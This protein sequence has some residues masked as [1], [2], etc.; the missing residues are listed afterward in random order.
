MLIAPDDRMIVEEAFITPP[1]DESGGAC[2]L[3]SRSFHHRYK[4]YR[5]RMQFYSRNR[6]DRCDAYR[7]FPGMVML[8]VDVAS[9]R[10]FES[11]LTGQDIVEFHY[12]LSGSIAIEGTWG[13][14]RVHDP[15]CLIWYQPTGCDDA[16]EQIGARGN[17]RETWISLYCDRA[18]LCERTGR[19]ATWLLESL[20]S[21]T[22]FGVG[23]PRFRLQ[24]QRGVTG[25]IVSD[26][27]QTRG[28]SALDWL[29]STAKATEL[30]CTTLKEARL[31]GDLHGSARR[32]SETDQR[33]LQQARDL[34]EAQFATPPRL[35]EL[36]RRVGMNPTKL[37]ALFQN[38]YGESMYD[39]VR[40]RRLE[41]A[42]EL[43][44]R[45]GLQVSQVA[46]AVGYRHHSTFTAAFTQ[47]FG[48]TPK[49]AIATHTVPKM[50]PQA[51]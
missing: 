43:L 34:L 8:I 35:P 12:R 17:G 47:H 29:Y 23:A 46:T 31:A 7:I 4:S 13:H 44:T 11:R 10:P 45:S 16:A 27:M 28:D 37:C 41:R 40:R 50:S 42:H 30:L 5:P 32:P 1:S 6:S 26:L 25:R 20:A 36:A 19:C 9:S 33:L 48:V 51:R 22:E 39:F 15:S 38:R 24:P 21:N 18:W 49:N 2:V 14:V 3:L